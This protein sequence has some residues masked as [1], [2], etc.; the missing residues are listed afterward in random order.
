ML[1]ATIFGTIILTNLLIA[2]MTTAYESV[3]EQ[4]KRQ[5]IYNKAELASDLSTRNRLMPPPLNVVVLV[6]ALV[7]DVFNLFYAL[8]IHPT[9]LN[10]YWY[11]DHQFF[12]NLKGWNIWKC[13]N[14]RKKQQNKHNNYK[15]ESERTKFKNRSDILEWY[16]VAW[17]YDWI[18]QAE[19]D[20]E[21][22]KNDLDWKIFHKACYGHIIVQSDS[23]KNEYAIVGIT[24][25]K[26]LNRHEKHKKQKLKTSVKRVLKQLTSNVLFC[27]CCYRS[28]SKD[29]IRN[30]LTTPYIALLDIISAILF[31]L[32]PIA[33]I[34][35]ILIF[36]IFAFK[37]AYANS[38]QS[39][40]LLH[41]GFK[42]RIATILY[43]LSDIKFPKYDKN[44][45]HGHEICM[46]IF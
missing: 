44:N 20:E 12:L 23:E 34:P 21:I 7:V 27:E 43:Y 9:K 41:G 16:F 25:E 2:K 10:I 6:I 19:T 32:I 42:N 28:F 17:F 14:D 30:E 33:W 31:V 36:S 4:A 3:E 11:I 24:M 13:K 45:F 1:L 29:N 18:K 37:D 8:I 15:Q 26:Y 22:L 46:F 39:Q 35:L 38:K 40:I 5:V